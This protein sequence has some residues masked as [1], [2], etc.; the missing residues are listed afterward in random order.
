VA[1]ALY[2]LLRRGDAAAAAK[3][4][5]RRFG[6][7]DRTLT[8]ATL[9]PRRAQSPAGK[10]Q[11]A[12]AAARLQGLATATAAPLRPPWKLL[13]WAVALSIALVALL[14]I[15]AESGTPAEQLSKKPAAE[16][17]AAPSAPPPFQSPLTTDQV[18]RSLGVVRDSRGESQEGRG[19]ADSGPTLTED[20]VVRRYFLGP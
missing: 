11:I 15:P 20:D 18:A 1:G 12:D 6:L 4:V 3:A 13:A 17:F 5:D 19:G 9:P 8:A 7:E 10:L 14:M 16:A 2:G